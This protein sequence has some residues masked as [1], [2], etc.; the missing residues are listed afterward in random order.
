MVCAPG[1]DLIGHTHWNIE[2]ISRAKLTGALGRYIAAVAGNNVVDIMAGTADPAVEVFLRIVFVGSEIVTLINVL[3]IHDCILKN[4]EY[5]CYAY[6]IVH[7]L[8]FVNII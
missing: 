3:I 6:R 1:V 7:F 4:I 5:W 2:K 8:A